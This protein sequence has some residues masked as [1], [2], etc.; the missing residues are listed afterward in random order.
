[1]CIKEMMLQALILD[2]CLQVSEERE[3]KKMGKG[4]EGIAAAA[5]NGER[6][7]GKIRL[8]ERI[9]GRGER[10]QDGE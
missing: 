5:E 4:L 2:N 8:G 9:G 3:W 6:D 1:M 7:R 10:E